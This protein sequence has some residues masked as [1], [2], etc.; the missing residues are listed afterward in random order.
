MYEHATMKDSYPNSSTVFSLLFN[1]NR[2]GFVIFEHCYRSF[3]VC[4]IIRTCNILY[5]VR[6]ITIK[7]HEFIL[8]LHSIIPLQF[9]QPNHN[10]YLARDALRSF[11]YWSV[12]PR[13]VDFLYQW[14]SVDG[15]K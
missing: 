9:P 7:E 11:S 10:Q 2:I 14:L 1:S 3:N 12:H 13:H 15:V 6:F 4:D 8:T 5:H